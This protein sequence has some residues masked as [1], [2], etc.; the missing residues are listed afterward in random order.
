MYKIDLSTGW[1]VRGEELWWGP[2]MST[3]VLGRT[4][5]WMDANLPCD[6]HMPLIENG[7]IKEPLEA[8]NCYECEWVENKSWWF[9]KVFIVDEE[10]LRSD[11]IELSLESL[12]AE[13]DVYLNGFHL[14]HQKSA[15]YPFESDIAGI[16]KK[17][18]NTLLVRLTSGLEHYS[19]SDL[20][21]IKKCVSTET[22]TNRRNRGDK[23]RAFVRKPQYAYG[24]DWGPRVATCG[25][26]GNAFILSGQKLVIRS[27]HAFTKSISPTALVSFEVEAENLHPYSTLEASVKIE[28]EYEGNKVLTLEKEVFMTSGINYIQFDAEI[29]DAN[30]WWPNGMGKP[31]LYTV[32]AFAC[33]ENSCA[34]YTPFKFGI[35]TVKI[36]QDRI[37]GDE[38]LFA[39]EINGVRTFCK[40]G[41]WIPSDSIYAR[42][43]KEKYEALIKEAAE[44]NFNMLRIWGGGLYEADIFYEKCDEYGIMLWHDFMFAC[45]LYPDNL[46]WFRNEVEKEIDY[47]TIRL[48]NHPSIVLWSGNNENHWGFDEWWIGEKKPPFLGGAVIYNKI[49]PSI[50]RKN[51]PQIPFWNS[52]P[53]GGER[54]NSSS[55]GD[56]HHWYDGF[57]NEDMNIRITP[58]EY[59]KLTAKFISEFGYVGPCRKSSIIKYHGGQPLDKNG[60][61]WQHHNN[62][63]EKETV[64]AGIAK[65]YADP[66]SLDIDKYLLYSGLCQ[67][68][69]Y[70]YSLETMRFKD[71][72]SGG[73]FWMYNDCWGEVGWTIIDYYLKRKIS[74]YFVSR[75]F[76]P[77]KLIMREVDGKI[78]V[79]GINDT[80]SAVEFDVLYGYTSFDGSS[81]SINT[82]S[83]KLE[84]YSRYQVL[85]FKKGDHDFKRGCCFVKPVDKS[86]PALPAALRTADFRQLILPEA[87]I[88]ISDFHTLSGNAVFTVSSSVYAHAV[89]FGLDDGTHLSDEYFDLL[90][91]ESRTITVYNA[92]DS[93]SANTIRAQYVK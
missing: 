29:N 42:V 61:I 49:I 73:I 6:I 8:E 52:S 71:F 77:V 53:Y 19:E 32:K 7:I 85:E 16:I 27:V 24:W 43:S 13:A 86:C 62:T 50:V 20:A 23:R 1:Q 69:M 34:K 78:T 82:N 28:L 46:E 58:E 87:Q 48:R 31:S 4:D 35:R 38:R 22:D 65:H 90:P 60:E 55:A 44:A 88:Q 33:A 11:I 81:S 39:F 84:P 64:P 54:P 9:K 5:G 15:F 92:P 75:A 91:G 74:Y 47:Q 68:L 37:S 25:I 26:T 83:L 17:D 80:S 57:M 70:G 14:G 3:A 93:L 66:D 89:H 30:L 36:N 76:A 10:A 18:E 72:C 12:D 63:F 59:D 79:M 21:P 2:D 67:G 40:G 45:A 56:R 51:C 41:D